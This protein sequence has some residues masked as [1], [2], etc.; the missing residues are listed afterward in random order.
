MFLY[1]LTILYTAYFILLLQYNDEQIK[2]L[3]ICV[4]KSYSLFIRLSNL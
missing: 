2:L 3:S 1:Y 4:N